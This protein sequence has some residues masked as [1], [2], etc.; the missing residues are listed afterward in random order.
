MA[1]IKGRVNLNIIV[2]GSE[3]YNKLC[4]IHKTSVMFK[5]LVSGGTKAFLM[6]SGLCPSQPKT[7]HTNVNITAVA[8]L[9]KRDARLTVKNIT[10]SVD[11]SG[12]AHKTLTQQFK[13]RKVCARWDQALD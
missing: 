12:S 4:Q 13:P 3:I 7:A 11:I 9:I 8:G 6:V 10:Y 5:T 1:Y 2:L